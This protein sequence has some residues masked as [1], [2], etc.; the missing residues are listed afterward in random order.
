MLKILLQGLLIGF[1]IAAPVGPIGILCINRALQGGFKAGFI[2]GLGAATADGVYGCLI[3]FGITQV[4]KWLI[5][6]QAWIHILGGIFLAYLGISTFFADP[7]RYTTLHQ[8]YK[9]WQAYLSTFFLTLTNP[10]TIL[11]F[12]GIFSGIHLPSLKTQLAFVLTLGITLGSALW[13]L[14]LSSSIVYLHV[15]IK[16]IYLRWINVF[17]SIVLMVY[18]INSFIQSYQLE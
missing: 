8:S 7:I 13:W 2:T 3:S 12:I 5:T 17:S 15:K 6:Q 9:A 18:S 4:T 1:S 11:V 14:L 16:T 10:M